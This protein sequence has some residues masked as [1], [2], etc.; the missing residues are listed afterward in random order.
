MASGNTQEAGR[1]SQVHWVYGPVPS[2]RLGRSLGIDLVPYKTCTYDCVYCQLGPTTEKIVERRSYVA[3]EVLFEQLKEALGH[4]PAPDYISLAGSGE[5]TLNKDIGEIIAGVK[6]ITSIPI[7]VLTN[8]SL[9][10]QREVRDALMGADVVL[11]SLDAG[12]EDLFTYVNHPHPAISFDLM[13][14]G[15]MDFIATFPGKVWLEVFLLAGVTAMPPEVE[16]LAALVRGLHPERV[17][18]NTVTRPPC[19]DFADP[20]S[21]AQM[22]SL[23]RLFSGTVEIVSG[24]GPAVSWTPHGGEQRTASEI[25]ELLKRRPC[26]LQGIASGLTLPPTEVVKHLDR[27]QLKGDVTTVASRSGVYY[28]VNDR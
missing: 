18:L 7:A 8:G 14:S 24:Q 17:Q 25:L 20:V 2:R 28:K 10:W 6:K 11:P 26:T 13:V 1:K 21:P 23:K 12:D 16:K 9:L 5:P 3:V 27:L 4:G 22:E 19:Q 15:L